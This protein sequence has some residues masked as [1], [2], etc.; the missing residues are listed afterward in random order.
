M[1]K[2]N[3]FIEPYLDFSGKNRIPLHLIEKVINQKITRAHNGSH[4]NA[5]SQPSVSVQHFKLPYV[6]SFSV[7][8]HRKLRKLA[9]HFCKDEDISLFSRRLKSATC[10]V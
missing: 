8:A 6:D 9:K 7:E 1:V 4:G 5:Q 10:L 3:R 2:E